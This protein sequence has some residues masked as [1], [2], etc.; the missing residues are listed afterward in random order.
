LQLRLQ[1]TQVDC[2]NLTR[3]IQQLRKDAQEPVLGSAALQ[4]RL[5]KLEEEN[6]SMHSMAEEN[7]KMR[8]EVSDLEA[9]LSQKRRSLGLPERPGTRSGRP[10]TAA[11]EAV[12]GMSEP[13]TLEGFKSNQAFCKESV[14]NRSNKPSHKGLKRSS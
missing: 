6:L 1:T 4:K 9:L 8:L 7:R 11:V 10:G 14:P 5:A 12:L 3:Q 2:G 13:S